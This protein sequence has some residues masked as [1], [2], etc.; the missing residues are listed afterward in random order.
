MESQYELTQ[1]IPEP[2]VILCP[3][4]PP[5]RPDLNTSFDVLNES[6]MEDMEARLQQVLKENRGLVGKV[7]TLEAI[8][9]TVQEQNTKLLKENKNLKTRLS[10]EEASHAGTKVEL[11][12]A[13]NR[14]N[15]IKA[16]VDA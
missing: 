6:F 9:K 10:S 8:L 11:N 7:A 15:K 4:S 13:R 5:F 3:S 14:L 2:S 12:C 1:K 16:M